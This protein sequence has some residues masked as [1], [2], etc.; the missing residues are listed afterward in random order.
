MM[1]FEETPLPNVWLIK[2]KQF[3]DGRGEFLETFRIELFKGHGIEFEYVQDNLSVSKKNTVRG[4]HYQ[5]PPSSQAKLVM[6][7]AGEILDVAVDM[8]THS[9]TFKQHFS[10][11]LSSS[12]RHMMFVPSGFAHGFSVLSD[13]ATVYYKCNDY[14]NKELERGVRWDDPDLKIDWMVDDPILSDK[15]RSLPLLENMD[16]KN[17]F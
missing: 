16:E 13:E 5:L 7:P 2:P 10:A 15:D 12:N 9:P 8:R 14:Y 17:L 11:K 6:V 1:K 3:K 4:L